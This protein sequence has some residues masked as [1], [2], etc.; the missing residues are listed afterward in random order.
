[1]EAFIRHR[2]RPAQV[3]V[4]SAGV[5]GLEG[6]SMHPFAAQA[7]R[8]SG[9]HTAA[10]HARQLRLEWVEQA[11]LTL[12]AGRRHRDLLLDHLP[13]AFARLFT[14]REFGWLVGQASVSG[15]R[16][17]AAVARVAH[18]QR[19]LA[20]SPMTSDIDLADPIGGDLVAFRQCR[21]RVEESVS[22]LARALL[23]RGESV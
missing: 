3:A 17:V 13:D 5:N 22:L 9:I 4:G 16:E 6:E 12:T 15:L 21:D 8:E 23:D 18:D 7:L 1:M 10:F 20:L 2:L 11:D 14:L 19:R